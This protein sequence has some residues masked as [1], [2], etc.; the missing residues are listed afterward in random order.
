MANGE[1][2]VTDAVGSSPDMAPA[3]REP[4]QVAALTPDSV[5]TLRERTRRRYQDRFYRS[6]GGVMG[7]AA[8]V[9]L[10]LLSPI[11]SDCSS[12]IRS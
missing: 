10:S 5:A 1:R 3:R 6:M 11:S 12:S 9:L 8:G 4:A 7:S 2:H